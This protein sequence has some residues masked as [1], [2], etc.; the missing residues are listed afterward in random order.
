MAK[1]KSV[2]LRNILNSAGKEALEV[3]MIADNNLRAI[4]S[5][6]SAVIP[7]RREVIITNN[8]NERRLTEMITEICNTEI[9]SQKSFD[10]ILNIYIKDLGSNICLPF[11][12]A[13]ARLMAQVRKFN[14]SAIYIKYC[15]L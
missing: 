13:F 1:I 4:A 7:G 6:P 11:S 5:S 15:K 8:V 3:E 2:Q 9:E 10:D 14:I 12:L